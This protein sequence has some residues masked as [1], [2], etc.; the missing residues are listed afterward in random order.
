MTL[1]FTVVGHNI[2]IFLNDRELV[3]DYLISILENSFV[4]LMIY[5]DINKNYPG[6]VSLA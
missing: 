1:F 3:N 4:M 2:R 6:L 5:R